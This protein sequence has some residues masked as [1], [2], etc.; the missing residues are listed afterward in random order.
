M[1]G[2]NIKISVV[3]PVYNEEQYL[4]QCISSICNQTYGDLEILLIDDGSS[5]R[6]AK[7]YDGYEKKDKRI[8]VFHKENGGSLSARRMGVEKATGNYVAFIDSDDWIEIDLYEKLVRVIIEHEPD[9]IGTSNYYRNYED[10]QSINTYDNKRTG[11]WKKN[12]FETEVFPYFIKEEEFFDTEFHISMWAYMFKVDFAHAIMEKM[13]DRIKT[14]ED[15]MFLMFALL[16]AKSFAAISYRGYHYRKNSNSK[17]H[18]L[19]NVK[20]L[21]QPVYETVDKAI[22]E[23]GYSRD[24]KERLRKKNQLHLYHAFMLKDYSELLNGIDRFLFPYSAVQ[25]GSRIFIYGAG[26]LGEQLYNAIKNRGNYI[27]AGVADKNWKSYRDQEWN[28]VSQEEILH[29]D[30][31][32]IIIAITYVNIRKQVKKNLV[33]MG[34]PENKFAEIDLNVMD[35]SHLPFEILG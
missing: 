6:C 29:R 15:Y 13:E 24:I 34:V 31:D 12:E 8:K 23:S 33:E 2:K 11:C 28:V 21:L 5:Q 16:N 9:I 22:M 17:T 30:Y 3:V 7:I 27:V 32:Y 19:K 10:G 35:K 25:S 18:H 26:K 14:S 20:E 4:E 1:I